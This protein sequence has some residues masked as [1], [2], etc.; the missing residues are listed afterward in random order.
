[1]RTRFLITLVAVVALGASLTVPA[2]AQRATKAPSAP[3]PHWPDG[4]VNLG[5]IGRASCR[6]RV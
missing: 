6:E 4:R 3:T 1:V 2:A 5:Q